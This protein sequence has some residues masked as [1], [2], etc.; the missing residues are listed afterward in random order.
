MGRA[1]RATENHGEH[2]H[3]PL[4]QSRREWQ[5]GLMLHGGDLTGAIAMFGGTR[6]DWLDLSTGI[7]PHAYPLPEIASRFWHSLPTKGDLDLLHQVARKAYKVAA[8]VGIVSAPGT[9]ALIQWMPLLAPAGSTAVLGPTY[10]E[11]ALAFQVAGRDVAEIAK[12]A[13]WQDQTKLQT[14]LIVVNPNNPDGR[15]LSLKSLSELAMKAADR[16]GWLIIDESFIDVA[17]DASAVGLCERLPVV[18]L[19]SFGKFYGLAGLRLGFAIAPEPIAERFQKAV[20]PW[21]TAGAALAVGPIALADKDWAD[22]M[23]QRL[24][25]EASRLDAVLTKAGCKVL[26]GTELYRLV[27][28]RDAASIHAYLAKHRIWVRKFDWDTGLLRFG[29]AGSDD[30]LARLEQALTDAGAH[31]SFQGVMTSSPATF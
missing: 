5:T 14:N 6:S 30:G 7:N 10:P 11:H 12:L 29:L 1:E 13:A 22:K 27:R 24:R 20:G 31:A 28:H 15:L 16:G 25:N 2:Q 17:P 3:N 8:S 9:Q 21:A 4:E 23:R 19:R 18:I 26:G